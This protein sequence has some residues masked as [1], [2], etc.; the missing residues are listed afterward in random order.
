MGPDNL[1]FYKAP[2]DADTACGLVAT[3]GDPLP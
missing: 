2:G 3:L 1:H